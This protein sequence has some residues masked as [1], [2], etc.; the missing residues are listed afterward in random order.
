MSTSSLKMPDS[1]LKH[2]CLI[3]SNIIRIKVKS[4]NKYQ[5]NDNVSPEEGNTIMFRNVVS[6]LLQAGDSVQHSHT[7]SLVV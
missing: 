5:C 2:V 6:N 3:L 4:S 1:D 7:E